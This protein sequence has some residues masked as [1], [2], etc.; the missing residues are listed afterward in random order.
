[1]AAPLF[2]TRKN[3]AA[4]LWSVAI[5]TGL[6]VIAGSVAVACP[7]C[8][9]VQQTLR[10]EMAAMDADYNAFHVRPIGPKACEPHSLHEVLS[11]ERLVRAGHSR[12]IGISAFG[13]I[14]SLRYPHR[15]SWPREAAMHW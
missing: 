10:Q 4:A 2:A 1:M 5:L 7:F 3:R 12:P 15:G 9:A 14:N 11:F 13:H 8:S 6:T